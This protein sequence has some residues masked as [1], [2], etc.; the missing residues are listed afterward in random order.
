MA[1]YCDLRPGETLS[2]GQRR[3]ALSIRRLARDGSA[4]TD[5]HSPYH[6]GPRMLKRG[7]YV[8][9]DARVGIYNF[10][11]RH[12]GRRMHLRLEVRGETDPEIEKVSAN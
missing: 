9:L 6:T 11:N 2:I 1:T 3:I 12:H 4:L 5:I 7:Q 10:G 8:R